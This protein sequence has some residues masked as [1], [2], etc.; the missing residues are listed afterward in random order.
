[1]GSY[2][3]LSVHE[4]L[5]GF[6]YPGTSIPLTDECKIERKITN[7]V[8][9]TDSRSRI[10][11][12]FVR[13][14]RS[15]RRIGAVC[16]RRS[17]G[18]MRY[19]CGGSGPLAH[20]ITPSTV[21]ENFRSSEMYSGRDGRTE[22]GSSGSEPYSSS[23]AESELMR[24]TVTNW[25]SESSSWSRVSRGYSWGSRG[26]SWK[27]E[28]ELRIEPSGSSS[29]RILSISFSYS[30][31]G[32]ATRRWEGMLSQISRDQMSSVTVYHLGCKLSFFA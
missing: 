20:A 24:G 10:F 22:V 23:L 14:L 5:T 26:V 19:L 28:E 11:A 17:H 18:V 29:R 25:L 31:I 1:M 3:R 32:V 9:T 15:T 16:Q 27:E 13:N 21:Q 2:Q 8:V 30:W 4:S 6:P 7:H 12:F